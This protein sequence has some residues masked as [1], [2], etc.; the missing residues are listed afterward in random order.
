MKTESI[1]SENNDHFSV[2]CANYGAISERKLN[3]GRM[4]PRCL[5]GHVN[6][7]K[8]FTVAPLSAA[9]ETHVRPEFIRL[10]RVGRRCP[11][12]GLSRSGLN[13]LILPSKLNGHRPQVRSVCLRPR[14]G[15][16]GTRL[17]CY[18]SL[19]EYLRNQ[20]SHIAVR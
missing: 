16:R 4:P 14:G 20:A 11:Y 3:G 5:R 2:D 1:I 13:N 12:T 15:V 7:P 19:I 6:S 18:D 8:G 17:I 9:D 10:P